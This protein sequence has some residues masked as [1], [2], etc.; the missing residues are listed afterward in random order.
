M[1]DL[2]QRF[3]AYR[4]VYGPNRT[5]RNELVRAVLESDY[6]RVTKLPAAE[7]DLYYIRGI[8][9]N[10]LNYVDEHEAMELL[11]DALDVGLDTDRLKRHARSVRNWSEWRSDMFRMLDEARGASA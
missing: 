5:A 8:L 9:R 10:R 1:S 6:D 3:N 11:T 7:R 2:A 4:T